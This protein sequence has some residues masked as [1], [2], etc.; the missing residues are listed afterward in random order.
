MTTH[1][2]LFAHIC[3]L[4]GLLITTPQTTHAAQHHA[5]VGKRGVVAA[6]HVLASQAG[7]TILK[8]GG[9]AVDAAC[10]TA[11]AVGVV[12][13]A[14][15]GIGGGGFMMLHDPKANKRIIID[16][17]ETAPAGAS[18]LMYLKKGLPKHPSRTG[19]LAVGIPGEVKGCAYAV[20]RYGKLALA[21]VLQPAIELARRGFPAGRHF[22]EGLKRYQ[23]HL[24]KHKLLKEIFYPGGK[25]P[26]LGQ[27]FRRPRLAKTLQAIAKHGPDVF[28]KGWIAKDIVDAVKAAGGILTHKDLTQ[29][30]VAIRHPLKTSFRG[31]EIYTMPPP[32]SGGAAI[33]MALNILRKMKLKTLGHN[34]ST[35]LFHLT[36]ALQ[37]AF[38]DRA[39]FMGDHPLTRKLLPKLTS[40][41]Y[42]DN[43]AKRITNKVQS[44]KA[45]GS[46]KRSPKA[47]PRDGGTSHISVIDKDGMAV[48]MTTTINTGYG[49]KVIAPRSGIILNN[50]MDD[51]SVAPDTPNAYGLIDTR[52][53]NAVAPGKRP[54]SSMTPTIITKEGE[55]YMVTGSPGGPRIISTVLLTILNVIDWKMDVGES[56]AASR[57][58]HQWMPDKLRVEPKTS[59]EVVDA[60]RG[61]GHEVEVSRREWS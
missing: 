38:A 52:G 2:P 28:Y 8:R 20:K 25:P 44:P 14:G 32:S 3:L 54:L 27:M 55:P 35:Y 34:S 17:R 47:S 51:F 45:Y 4:A 12:N 40:Q 10:A 39:R 57:Y 21:Q 9:N 41:E 49:S 22:V 42:A 59:P 48:A 33:I 23:K 46:Q 7:L 31:H 58:H 60:L 26:T 15:S 56:V 30:K 61:M 53:A 18:R 24:S 19:G 37:H 5:P 1:R 13:P 16:F 50:E 6:D 43:L 11:F 36:E 29:Y